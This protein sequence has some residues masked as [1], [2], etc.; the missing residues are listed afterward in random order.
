[1][2]LADLSDA[3]LLVRPVPGANHAAWQLGHL[4]GFNAMVLNTVAP[5]S[6]LKL[7]A[8]LPDFA[9][10]QSS[11]SDD[12]SGFHTKSELLSALEEC[13]SA[14]LTAVGTMTAE[15]FARPA[16]EAV[17]AFA[18]TLGV[19]LLMVPMH[20]AMHVGQIQVIRRKLGR[21]NIM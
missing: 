10:R 3:D 6:S 20:S 17:R 4:I 2:H 13:E 7:P 16:P 11:A 19:L 1:M 8:K 21:P 12:A 9:D 5:M 14:L 15:D 18:P